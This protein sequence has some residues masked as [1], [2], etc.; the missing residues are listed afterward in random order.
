MRARSVSI[1]GVVAVLGW[2]ACVAAQQASPGGV[3]GAGAANPVPTLA[4]LREAYAA[5][6]YRVAL[7]QAPR[8]LATTQDPALRAEL[9]YLR[10]QC[11]IKL[12]DAY[13]AKLALNAAEQEAN[14]AGNVGESRVTGAKARADRLLIEA[15]KAGKVQL[16]G[17]EP[18]ALSDDAARAGLYAGLLEVK[19][20][21]MSPAV[22]KAESARDL[23]TIKEV[24]PRA[25]DVHALELAATGTEEKSTAIYRGLGSRAR[26]LLSTELGVLQE[27]IDGIRRNAD[28]TQTYTGPTVSGTWWG[29]VAVRRG[30][31]STDRDALRQT[32]EQ[33]GRVYETCEMAVNLAQK[34]GSQPQGWDE[35]MTRTR[36]LAERAKSVLEGE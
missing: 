11:L 7:Q 36:V 23:P 22:A 29:G 4:Q 19:L 34:L 20:E 15:S 30:L 3:G 35:L 10:G 31:Y 9:H 21:Q 18:T 32:I 6:E 25:F 8:T 14:K 28:Q 12:D 33:L 26:E 17:K 24:L 16:P 1:V 27:R 2:T 13:T 5:G